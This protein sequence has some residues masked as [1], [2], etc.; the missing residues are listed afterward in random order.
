LKI[1]YIARPEAKPVIIAGHMPANPLEARN[2][3]DRAERAS[4]KNARV[5]DKI[6]IALPRELDPAQRA[7]LVRAFMAD[8]TGGRQ[9]PWFACIHQSGKDAANPHVHIDVHDR[10]IGTGLR[11]LRLSDSTRDRIKA[12]LPGPKA[13]E[14]IR[15]RWE[16]VCNDALGA[17]GHEVRID[18]RTLA[19][20]AMESG[21]GS[22][23]V[24][25]TCRSASAASSA[26]FIFAQD[27][28]GEAPLASAS[29][30]RMASRL[31]RP[32]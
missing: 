6:R 8:L 5:M 30:A 1:R 15:E 21:A 7:A 11:V 28:A 14:W 29:A 9:V 12:G 20:S 32:K 16:A 31:T 18:R 27:G 17:A 23:P 13:V 26:F 19:T 25:A 3:I 4:R 24:P 10:E 2:W 22:Q